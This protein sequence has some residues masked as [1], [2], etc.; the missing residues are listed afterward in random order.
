MVYGP[1]YTLTRK[2][3]QEKTIA[4]IADLRAKEE[5]NAEEL[6]SLEHELVRTDAQLIVAEKQLSTITHEQVKYGF[7]YQ[8]DA[9]Q[10]FGEKLAIIA[11]YGKHLLQLVQDVPTSPEDTQPKYSAHAASTA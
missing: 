4:K 11:G 1:R 5:P 2:L 9:M 10:E 6:E 8:F 7:A 3:E